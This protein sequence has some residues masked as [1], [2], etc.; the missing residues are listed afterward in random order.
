MVQLRDDILSMVQLRDD[1]LSMVQLGYDILSMVQLR[2]DI[3]SIGVEEQAFF[4]AE[5]TSE[6]EIFGDL[7]DCFLFRHETEGILDHICGNFVYNKTRTLK[8][9]V[10]L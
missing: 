5:F 2:D 3:L 10:E 1:I 8:Y 7:G 9:I 6:I 4:F